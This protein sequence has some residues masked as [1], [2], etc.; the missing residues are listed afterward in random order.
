MRAIVK[1]AY[2]DRLG[3]HKIGSVVEVEDIAKMSSL[4]E[5]LDEGKADEE[6]KTE[7]KK[8]EKPKKKPAKKTT[9]KG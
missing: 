6:E 9:K 4:V 5:P 3:L 2:F 7:T 8:E 1:R